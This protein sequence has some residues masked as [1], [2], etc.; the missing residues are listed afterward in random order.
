MRFLPR[1]IPL[2]AFLGVLTLS[3][4]VMAQ[5]PVPPPTPPSSCAS[6]R[7]LRFFNAGLL[8]GESLV[9]QAWNSPSIGQSCEKFN[10]FR[11]AVKKV[12]L[13]LSV[14]TGWPQGV[15][16]QK[17]GEVAG[18]IARVDEIGSTCSITCGADGKF[19][20]QMAAFL[21]CQLSVALGG[22]G[23]DVELLEGTTGTCTEA[24]TQACEETFKSVTIN[25]KETV[26]STIDCRPFT[27]DPFDDVWAQATHNQCLYDPVEPTPTPN[28]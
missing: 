19:V 5:T 21:Y 14:P 27:I 28:P 3:A 17:D 13:S 11:D 18:A 22:L 2:T 26:D 20:G 24:F 23:M 6:G 4:A 12:F 16:C 10:Q 25:F 9:N 8:K 7:E 15:I 1:T